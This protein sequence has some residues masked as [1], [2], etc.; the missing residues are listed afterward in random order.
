[1]KCCGNDGMLGFKFLQVKLTC[2]QGDALLLHMKHYG[3]DGARILASR[4]QA[5]Q[6]QTATKPP[7][8]HPITTITPNNINPVTITITARERE[9][10]KRENKKS[11]FSLLF[12]TIPRSY[13]KKLFTHVRS[14]V[15][16]VSLLESGE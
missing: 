10:I 7:H 16:A 4:I 5:H 1:M 11:V 2:R 12:C 9:K 13:Y 3:N 15:S 8:H 6:T 14:H